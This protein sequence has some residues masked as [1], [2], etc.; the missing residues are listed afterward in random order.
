MFFRTSK[1]EAADYA[2][3]VFHEIDLIMISWV[4]G[5]FVKRG[6]IIIEKLLLQ[7]SQDFSSHSFVP[8]SHTSYLDLVEHEF[9]LNRSCGEESSAPD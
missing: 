7:F 8:P 6:S 4:F 3:A 9:S 5:G 2:E 1:T